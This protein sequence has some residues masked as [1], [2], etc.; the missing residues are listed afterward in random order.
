MNSATACAQSPR[1]DGTPP[2]AAWRWLFDPEDASV[3]PAADAGPRRLAW[4][5]LA[6]NPDYQTAF[7]ALD[8]RTRGPVAD[9]D[10]LAQR[11]AADFG[12]DGPRDPRDPCPPRFVGARI[13]RPGAGWQPA[14]SQIGVI[15]DADLPLDLQLLGITRW[16]QV[17]RPGWHGNAANA[18]AAR[19]RMPA[20]ERLIEAL[21][22]WDWRARG[23]TVAGVGARVYPYLLDH[24]DG[25]GAERARKRAE[26][27]LQW[28][29]YLILKRGYLQLAMEATDEPLM[30]EKFL[31]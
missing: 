1:D 30:E 13:V 4:A 7:G 10:E 11:I 6:R 15:L 23:L 18:P 31:P 2:A 3:Y 16:A 28:A 21:R 5:F 27:R 12:I 25:D 22:A 19:I 26:A 20:P 29:D 9:A 17:M 8:A 24:A 14:P